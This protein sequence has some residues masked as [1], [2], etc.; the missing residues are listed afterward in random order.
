MYDVVGGNNFPDTTED[1]SW[2][3]LLIQR[4]ASYLYYNCFLVYTVL[5]LIVNST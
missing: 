2:N 3:Q 5:T 4:V 1:L